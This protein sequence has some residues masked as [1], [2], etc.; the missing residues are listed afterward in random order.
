[1][2]LAVAAFPA[3]AVGVNNFFKLF[4]PVFDCL[5]LSSSWRERLNAS[6]RCATI[7]AERFFLISVRFLRIFFER[8]DFAISFSC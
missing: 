5:A 3:A 8:I 2:V 7:G 6:V 4:N 1:M